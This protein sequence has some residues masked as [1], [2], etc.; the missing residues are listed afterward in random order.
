M[1]TLLGAKAFM[2]EISGTKKCGHVNREIFG[3]LKAKGNPF[4]DCGNRLHSRFRFH[5][6]RPTFS[7]LHL[8]CSCELLVKDHLISLITGVILA[9]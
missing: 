1:L 9:V 2:K 3:T 8:N 5:I 6:L 7:K 4:Q